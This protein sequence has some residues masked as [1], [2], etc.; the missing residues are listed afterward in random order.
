LISECTSSEKAAKNEIQLAAAAAAQTSTQ[1]SA[2]KL[3]DIFATPVT[4]ARP[5]GNAYQHVMF[6]GAQ[7]TWILGGG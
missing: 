4:P 6:I 5:A 7:V 2:S 1:A 3:P